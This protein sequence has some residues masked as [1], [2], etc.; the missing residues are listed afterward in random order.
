MNKKRAIR[1]F[2]GT[3]A[4]VALLAMSATA[5]GLE[6]S[7]PG[8][9]TAPQGDARIHVAQATATFSDDQAD[10][11]KK[12]YNSECAECHGEDLN[13]GLLGGPPLKGVNFEQTYFDGAPASG[14]FSFMS[15]LMPP[16][17][18]GRFSPGQYAEIMAYILQKNGFQSGA[19]LPSDSAKL[20]NLILQK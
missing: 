13:G 8:T 20:D 1:L 3:M 18:P 10:K 15:T 14:L 5:Y 2:G 6:T 19:E 9:V 4:S 16:N 11:G 17:D 7:T 12:R